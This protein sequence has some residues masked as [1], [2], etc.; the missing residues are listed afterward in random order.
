MSTDI[1]PHRWKKLFTYSD[2]E[3]GSDILSRQLPHSIWEREGKGRR[4]GEGM[5]N[6][7]CPSTARKGKTYI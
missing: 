4:G 1:Q 6:K 2:R 5:V 7:V 3:K